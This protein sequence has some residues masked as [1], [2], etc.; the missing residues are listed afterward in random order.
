MTCAHRTADTTREGLGEVKAD[1]TSVYKNLREGW[2]KDK[3]RLSSAVP[4][5][6]TR[7][8][9]HTVKHRGHPL[10]TFLLHYRALGQ[11]ARRGCGTSLVGDTQKPSR[12]GPGKGA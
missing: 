6:R 3:A 4:S 11:V 9:G 5:A 8:N 12:H 2:K 1:F 7:S 10:N